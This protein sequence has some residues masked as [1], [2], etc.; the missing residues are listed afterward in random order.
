MATY[1]AGLFESDIDELLPGNYEIVSR[2]SR[3][4]VLCVPDELVSYPNWRQ[5]LP[6]NMEAS[7]SLNVTARTTASICLAA[8]QLMATDYLVDACGFGTVHKKTDSAEIYYAIPKAGEAVL[9]ENGIGK[10]VVMP[11]RFDNPE[12]KDETKCTAII[13]SL[14]KYCDVD[15][16]ARVEAP[17]QDEEEGLV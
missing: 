13:P 4:L 1:D 2:S 12:I 10:A 16:P 17:M 6:A 3:F 8:R 9:I 5:V 15:E 7:I 11:M 14:E